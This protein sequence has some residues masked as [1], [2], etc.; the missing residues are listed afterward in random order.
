MKAKDLRDLT[1]DELRDKHRQ[2]KE[3][4]FNLRFQHAIGQLGNTG[5]IGDV[6]RSIAKVLTVMRDK[7][8][9]LTSSVVR[10]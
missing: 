3:E 1:L 5:R 2:Y 6:K 8:L 7:E 9:G 4:L 10:R